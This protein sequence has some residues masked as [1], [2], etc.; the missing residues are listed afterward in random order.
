MSSSTQSSP[1]IV[2]SLHRYIP[3]SLHPSKRRHGSRGRTAED[4]R[5]S[6]T[7]IKPQTSRPHSEASPSFGARRYLAAAPRPVARLSLVA[8]A[9][10]IACI[11]SA[12]LLLDSSAVNGLD[13]DRVWRARGRSYY[14]RPRE[15][16]KT[17]YTS[18]IQSMTLKKSYY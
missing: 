17:T 15:V 5:V 12:V 6:Y 9:S 7:Q 8:A 2:P 4:Q 3:P 11:T 13:W 16:T 10:F 14:V 18:C 1:S